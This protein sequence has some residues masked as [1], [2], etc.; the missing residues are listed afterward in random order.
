MIMK[1]QK[2]ERGGFQIGTTWTPPVSGGGAVIDS[3][4]LDNNVEIM[5]N[6]LDLLGDRILGRKC[7]EDHIRDVNGN[8][9]V[10]MTD[11]YIEYTLWFEVLKVGN[12]C[13]YLTNDY[14]AKNRVFMYFPEWDDGLHSIGNDLFIVSE[15]LMEGKNPSLK[16]F[17]AEEPK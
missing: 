6:S 7:R 10:A 16:P 11:E 17:I 9:L 8:M 15:Q 14:L 4:E 2:N 5:L 12:K 3:P 1:E 13:K